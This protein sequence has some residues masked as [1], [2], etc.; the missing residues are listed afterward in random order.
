M[1]RRALVLSAILLSALV[2]TRPIDAQGPAVGTL[3]APVFHHLH[4]NSVDPSGM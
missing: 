2:L 4:V 3:A 1:L